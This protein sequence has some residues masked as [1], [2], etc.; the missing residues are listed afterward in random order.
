[1]KKFLL[2]TLVIIKNATVII[3]LIEGM[4]SALVNMIEADNKIKLEAEKFK[5]KSNQPVANDYNYRDDEH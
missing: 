5:D 3:P 4:I 1:M 2:A